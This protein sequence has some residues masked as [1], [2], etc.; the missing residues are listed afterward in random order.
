MCLSRWNARLAIQVR[1]LIDS[2]EDN[3]CHTFYKPKKMKL[4]V[5]AVQLNSVLGNVEENATRALKLLEKAIGSSQKSP[6]LIVLPEMA[7]TGYNF[8]SPQHVSPFLESIGKGKSYEFGKLVSEKWNCLTLLGYPEKSEEKIYNSAV[9]ID[10]KGNIVYNYRKTHLYETDKLWGCSESPHGF[11]S[12]DVDIKGRKI[13]S[14][15]GICMDLNPYEFTAPFEAYEFANVAAKDKCELVLVPTA[16]MNSSWKENWSNEDIA[17]FK[18]VYELNNI[19]E[20]D[21]IANDT[22]DRRIYYSDNTSESASDYNLEM[23]DS[24]T[25]RYWIMR[26]NPLFSKPHPDLTQAVII[27]NRSGMEDRLMYAGTSSIFTFGGGPM[28][29]DGNHVTIDA[30][31]YGS[32]GQGTEGILIRDIDI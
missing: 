31:V 14:I 7:L 25:A 19:D 5:A 30:K 29:E 8:R 18:K 13:K 24:R 10:P 28:I 20:I 21:C 17:S 22:R 16:W 9:L 3:E 2:F 12:F 15:I 32:L 4:R 27:C 1:I 11:R 23:T 6:D 26:L